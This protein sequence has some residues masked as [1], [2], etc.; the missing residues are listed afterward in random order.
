MFK[1]LIHYTVRGGWPRNLE[2]PS[3]ICGSIAKSIMEK[4]GNN[5]PEI[6]C[7]ICGMSNIAYKRDSLF[8]D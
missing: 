8:L 4:E 7:V 3:S 2:D 6:L 5:P 1:R